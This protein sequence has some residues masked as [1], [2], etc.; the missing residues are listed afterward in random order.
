VHP[1][2]IQRMLKV[3]FSQLPILLDVVCGEDGEILDYTE[4]TAPE[5]VT[6]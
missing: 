3:L 2:D 1:D 5:V 6:N 4:I